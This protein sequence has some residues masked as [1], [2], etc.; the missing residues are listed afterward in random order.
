MHD[1]KRL[2]DLKASWA[3]WA[4]ITSWSF[5][6]PVHA[7]HD[8]FGARIAFNFAWKGVYCKA[9]L[10]LVPLSLLYEVAMESA[11]LIRTILQSGAAAEN[12]EEEGSRVLLGFSLVLVTWG[13][14]AQNLWRREE[15]FFD[16]HWDMDVVHHDRVI[17]PH[18]RGEMAPSNVDLNLSERQVSTRSAV[19]RVVLSD[20][21]NG[22]CCAVVAGII[23]LQR[24]IMSG[25]M[26]LLLSVVFTAQ[27]NFFAFVYDFVVDWLLE[28]ENQKYQEDWYNSYLRKQFTFQ[29]VNNYFPFVLLAIKQAS[30]PESVQSSEESLHEVRKKLSM[31]LS[32]LSVSRIFEVALSLVK[33]KASLWYRARRA[34]KPGQE[35]TR[36]GGDSF[37]E[38]QSGYQ[39]FKS[40][41]QI[42]AMLYPVISLGHV[43]LFGAAAPI[44]VPLCLLVFVM[45]R[46]STAFLLTNY[47]KRPYPRSSQGLGAWEGAVDV[48]MRIGLLTTGCILVSFGESFKGTPLLTRSFGLLLF[49]LTAL[50]LWAAVD[51]CCPGSD[52]FAELLV[53]RRR[54][55]ER[56]LQNVG[57]R[58]EDPETALQE[59]HRDPVMDAVERG[60]WDAIEGAADPGGGS[61]DES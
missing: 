39:E 55:V 2:K 21:A 5:V 15:R 40:R 4:S 32:I 11:P 61:G 31:T 57:M 18:F 26:T 3:S 30:I 52:G 35:K 56:A 43:L 47:A 9:L 59:V 34:M 46:A 24:R 17:R 7:I 25:N 14:V 42:W 60:D 23:W 51:A 8:Y 28:F 22:F 37:T 12:S 58:R 13:R 19:A 41:E 33:V 36:T 1:K 54:R 20:V 45:A 48:L 27:I 49:C 16:S 38:E 10:A 6:Q 50:G 53:E 44:V 29:S